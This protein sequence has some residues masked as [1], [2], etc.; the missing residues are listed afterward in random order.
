MQKVIKA[1]IIDDESLAIENLKSLLYQNFPFVLLAGSSQT[2]E[3]AVVEIPNLKIDVLFLDI[4]LKN[5]N[6]FDLFEQLNKIDFRVIFVTAYSE[7]AVKAFKYYALDYILKPIDLKELRIAIDKCLIQNSPPQEI[8][9]FYAEL[10]K[11]NSVDANYNNK[12]ILKHQ[13]E[14]EVLKYSEIVYI[15]AD[16]SYCI[17]HCTN[18]RKVVYSKSSNE[19]EKLLPDN[20]FLRI[21]KSYIINK[22][23]IKDNKIGSKHV[24]LTTG[25]NLP[26]ARR[27][28]SDVL[29]FFRVK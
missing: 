6:G 10:N 27:R 2:I 8:E 24:E 4:E 12:I 23:F 3:N 18:N 26:I 17:F 21:H 20:L 29:A 19:V 28:F 25:V 15:Q 5:S 14:I 22:L 11:S 1:Y 13:N 9:Q 16:S 7:Y